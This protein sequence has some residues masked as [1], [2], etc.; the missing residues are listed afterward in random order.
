M[1]EKEIMTYAFL[2]GIVRE[3]NECPY[4]KESYRNQVREMLNN[5]EELYPGTKHSI[6]SSFMEILPALQKQ[7]KKGKIKYCMKCK[8]PSSQDVCQKC[9]V[10]EQL[11]LPQ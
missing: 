7:E 4:N 9:A 6:V 8:E 5:F 1:S 2:K 10:L 3:F 11:K